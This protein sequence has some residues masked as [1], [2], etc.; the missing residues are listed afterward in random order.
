[1]DTTRLSSKGQIIIP[2]GVRDA[3]GWKEGMEFVV[4][5]TTAGVLLRPKRL[6]RRT[7]V[8]D[9][10]GCATYT[11]PSHTIDEMDA[12]ILAEAARRS[13]QSSRK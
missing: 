12:A 3:H 4:E 6:F 13:K 11:G 8:K 5:T 7:T 2:K 9:V 1:M 10:I